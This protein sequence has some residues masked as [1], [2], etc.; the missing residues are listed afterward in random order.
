MVISAERIM[1]AETIG[2]LAGSNVLGEVPVGYRFSEYPDRGP[3]AQYGQPCCPD[4]PRPPRVLSTVKTACA[5][6]MGSP[7]DS[8]VP[9]P[10]KKSADGSCHL[11]IPANS[12]GRSSRMATHAN[13]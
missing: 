6:I 5:A 10:L 2:A 1:A 11:V 8:A 13:R 4:L 12:P 7:D 9:P 3:Y